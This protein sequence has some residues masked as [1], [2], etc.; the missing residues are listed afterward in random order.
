MCTG[1][2][3]G[4]K[5][6]TADEIQRFL[7]PIVSDLLRLWKTGIKVK[8]P[9]CPHGEY[10]ESFHLFIYKILISIRSACTSYPRCDRMRQA[11]ST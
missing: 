2:M 7:R 11:R 6:Q 10:C 3:P 9:S 5:E 1:I 4:P 8:T